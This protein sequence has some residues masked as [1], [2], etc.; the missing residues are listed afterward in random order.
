MRL[1]MAAALGLWLGGPA[2]AQE[3][4]YT[5][6]DLAEGEAE[7]L[8]S[9]AVC[10]GPDG[11]AMS[12]VEL[13]RPFLPRAATDADLEAIMLNGIPGTPMPPANLNRR[14]VDTLIG[15]VR[16]LGRAGGPPGQGDAGRGRT[17]FEGRGNCLSCHRV[18]GR[19]S[20]TGPDLS[21]IGLRRRV[22]QLEAS[23]VDPNAEI[24]AE[25]RFLTIVAV[26]GSVTRGRILNQNRQSVQVV[27]PDGRPA[28][29]LKSEVRITPEP[30]S[31]MPSA[32][33]FLDDG[34]I[35]DLVAYLTT[36]RGVR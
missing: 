13:N 29:Y 20:R 8:N 19:G 1:A 34:E 11:D 9:C 2:S 36:L 14:Q 26:D 30:G 33:G 10:H 27:G 31:P 35:A 4:G 22:A 28:T 32:R 15:Y 12:G 21:D 23:L 24:R 5:V 3:A 7:F 6:A 16:S 25:N 18:A 17:V